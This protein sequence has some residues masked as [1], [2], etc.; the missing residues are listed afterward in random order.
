MLLSGWLFADLLLG[1]M[2]IFMISIP[3]R[4]TLPPV[5]KVN[6]IALSPADTQHCQGGINKPTCTITLSEAANSEGNVNWTASSDMGDGIQFNP[7]TG[8]LSPGKSAT[9]KIANIPCQNGF[10]TFKGS[11]DAAPAVVT[12]QCPV[13]LEDK[14]VRFNLNVKVQDLLNNS[15]Q[16]NDNIKQQLRSQP[17]LIN[18]SVGLAIVYGGSGNDDNRGQALQIATSIYRVMQSMQNETPFTTF[19]RASYYETLIF[20]GQDPSIVTVDVYRYQQ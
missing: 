6:P 17:L 8:T 20:L 13:K 3:P 11:R 10:L 19:Q 16:E 12:W 15:P 18:R 14:T 7:P 4:V 5:L 2:A 9:L 1:L